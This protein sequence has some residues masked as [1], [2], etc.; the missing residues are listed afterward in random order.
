MLQ[1][2]GFD[3]MFPAMHT[4]NN[5]LIGNDFSNLVRDSCDPGLIESYGVCLLLLIVLLIVLLILLLIVLLI[6]LLLFLS[7]LLALLLLLACYSFNSCLPSLLASVTTY[8]RP[9]IFAYVCF[10]LLPC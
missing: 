6:V 4:R 8:F 3:A 10:Y 7:P 2:W 9:C 1:V 5:T